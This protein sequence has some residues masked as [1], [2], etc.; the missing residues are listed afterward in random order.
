MYIFNFTWLI[1]V[2]WCNYNISDGQED[3]RSKGGLSGLQPQ[4]GQDETRGSS[5]RRWPEPAGGDSSEV[6][7]YPSSVGAE[8]KKL[9]FEISIFIF[10][11]N[12][13]SCIEF[14]CQ[15]DRVFV[16]FLEGSRI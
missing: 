1:F 6:G 10:L 12:I 5:P 2:F 14:K 8:N 4:Q 9:K 3:H 7:I 16:W 11:D 13:L 15:S